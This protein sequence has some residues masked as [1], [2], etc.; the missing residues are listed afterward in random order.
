MKLLEVTERIFPFM[1]KLLETDDVD[2]KL[3]LIPYSQQVGILDTAVAAVVVTIDRRSAYPS[4][5]EFL[6][7]DNNEP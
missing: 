1:S 6:C 5:E 3:D 4:N 2:H 7:W